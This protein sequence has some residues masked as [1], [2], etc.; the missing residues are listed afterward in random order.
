MLFEG[1]GVDVDTHVSGAKTSFAFVIATLAMER[2]AGT[3]IKFPS[4]VE[5]KRSNLDLARRRLAMLPIVRSLSYLQIN[6]VFI[7]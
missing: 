4:L 7:F 2:S 3:L 5:S 1:P 6:F